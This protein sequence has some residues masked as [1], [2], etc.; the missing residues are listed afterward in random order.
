MPVVRDLVEWLDNALTLSTHITNW[1]VA[2][3][4]FVNCTLFCVRC[5]GFTRSTLV[6]LVLMRLD[7]CN[8]VILASLPAFKVDRLQTVINTAARFVCGARR[9]D[10]IT[11]LLQQLHWLLVS[12]GNEFTLCVLT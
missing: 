10:Y 11:Q 12:E 9:C 1:S 3:P 2:S 6:A 7:Y 5:R 4:P 8:S